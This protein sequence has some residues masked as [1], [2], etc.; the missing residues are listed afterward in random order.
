MQILRPWRF[1]DRNWVQ[2]PRSA[3]VGPI[4]K[5][6]SDSVRSASTVNEPTVGPMIPVNQS[7][8]EPITHRDLDAGLRTS[9]RIVEMPMSMSDV[10]TRY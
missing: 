3:Y 1:A 5:L 9:A 8:R 7:P 6:K 2:T 4:Q 10:V